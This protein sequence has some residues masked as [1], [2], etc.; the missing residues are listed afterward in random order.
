MRA[1]A[2]AAL[3]TAGCSQI[4][5]I[6]TFHARDGGG[7]DGSDAMFLDGAADAPVDAFVPPVDAPAHGAAM[8]IA[9]ASGKVPA[10]LTN[11]PVWIDITSASLVDVAP[12]TGTGLHFTSTDG[13]PLDYELQ[14]WDPT[15]GHV[16]A[17][18]RLATLPSTGAS[19]QLRYGDG[20]TTMSNG[21][22]VFPSIS[23]F[24]NV[25]HME[26]T[27]TTTA[28][29]A[30]N[31]SASGTFSGSAS[32]SAGLLGKARAFTGSQTMAF[33]NPIIGNGPF[34]LSMWIKIT[35]TP[36]GLIQLGMNGQ[37]ATRALVAEGGTVVGGSIQTAF[38]DSQNAASG[39][40]T[41]LAWTYDGSSTSTVVVNANV[42]TANDKFQNAP[43]NQGALSFQQ[44]S[45]LQA[46][47]INGLVDEPR[48]ANVGRTSAWLLTEYANQGSASSFYSVGSAVALP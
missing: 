44:S 2:M 31:G 18:V 46:N 17:W 21:S 48:I 26:D 20:S 27:S 40:W 34:T 16:Q 45:P 3:V 1:V 41:Y 24:T 19:F 9:I 33:V 32:T 38:E 7:G 5:G 11:F 15:G 13:T 14:G 39:N 25:W 22:A 30:T 43:T 23:G 10:T 8:T 47:A 37:N 6:D 35:Q 29:D 36:T 42:Y 4:L 12:A 28:Q